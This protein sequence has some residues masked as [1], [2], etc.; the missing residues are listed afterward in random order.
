MKSPLE[1]YDAAFNNAPGCATQPGD[2]RRRREGQVGH[3]QQLRGPGG[4][5]ADARTSRA[6]ARCTTA[7]TTMATA[8]STTYGTRRH[9]RHPG[10]VGHLPRVDAG[11]AACRPSR[12][13]RSRSTA[14][15]S[16][17]ATS[18][19]CTQ[20]IFDRTSAV[21]LGGRCNNKE[22]TH[23]VTGSA[24][25][26]CS[27]VNPGALHV[28]LTN[29]LGLRQAPLIEDRTANYEVWNQPVVGY[30]VTKQAKIT[31]TAA[32][33]VRRRDRQQRGRTTPAA[34]K[35]YEVRM[36]VTYITESEREAHAGRLREQHLA[37]TT[38]TT[39]S[40]STPTARSS[41]AATA[42]TATNTPH[43]LPVVADRHELAVEP[44]RRRREGQ[45]AHQGLGRAARRAAAAAPARRASSRSRRA[46]PSRTTTRPASPSTSR[47]PAS[48][49]RRASRSR[50]TSRTRTA[51]TSSSSSSRTA[52]R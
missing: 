29:F 12:S 40:S 32:N 4:E 18:R 14:S 9:R 20:N 15:R 16:R 36:T 22:I 13:T 26:E 17:S 2:V 50:S 31:A 8:R 30:E 28:I 49:A 39:S 3:V 51:V 45:A 5:V 23:D 47:S 11:L 52:R 44:E 42:P 1:K 6:A 41:A 37:R 43:R 19:R 21:M 38:T 27:D 33:A 34:K 35:L 48:P 7:S 46:R 10:L 24:N 25:D